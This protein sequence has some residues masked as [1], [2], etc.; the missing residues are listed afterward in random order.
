MEYK[1]LE[2]KIENNITIT[3]VEYN[4]E[5]RIVIVDITHNTL[6]NDII[7]EG[8]KNR[9]KTEEYKIFPERMPIPPPYIEI[10]DENLENN[11]ILNQ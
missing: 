6:D 8:V 10:I 2:T 5:G 7:I 11:E 1:I 9:Y 4:I 3:K